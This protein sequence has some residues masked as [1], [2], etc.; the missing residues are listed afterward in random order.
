MFLEAT[1]KA[2]ELLKDE[3]VTFPPD[4]QYHFL[5]W[6]KLWKFNAYFEDLGWIDYRRFNKETQVIC[7][8]SI[9]T[10]LEDLEVE[11]SGTI[12]TTIIKRG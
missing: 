5:T 4:W 9:H 12:Q 10:D 11:P 6:C 7:K 1:I 8:N 3:P 2:K